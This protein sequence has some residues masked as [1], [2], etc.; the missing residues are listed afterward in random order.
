MLPIIF[1]C[2]PSPCLLV[3]YYP[4][5]AESVFARAFSLSSFLV[6]CSRVSWIGH[7][8]VSIPPLS[9]GLS[10]LG[11]HIDDESE[12]LCNAK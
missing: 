7:P 3:L 9:L 6:S 1:L 11:R 4:P 12:T 5:L 10:M 2:A 8:P